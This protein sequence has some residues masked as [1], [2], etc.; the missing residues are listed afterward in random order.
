MLCPHLSR[1]AVTR[2]GVLMQVSETVSRPGPQCCHVIPTL[3]RGN[4]AYFK[5]GDFV[6][7]LQHYG[8]FAAPGFMKPEGIVLYHTAANQ[9]FKVTLENDEKPKNL[10]P[11]LKAEVSQLPS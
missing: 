2:P 7:V 3:W 9:C 6:E 5:A 11:A 10:S 8:S 1:I 4:C